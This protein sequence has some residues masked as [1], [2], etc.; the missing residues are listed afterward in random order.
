[1]RRKGD[2]SHGQSQA[3]RGNVPLIEVKSQESPRTALVTSRVT[4]IRAQEQ[5]FQSGPGP[6][7]NSG[8]G[9]S[10]PGFKPQHFFVVVW[11]QRLTM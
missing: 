1:M 11:R 4:G 9:G 7:A 2:C 5:V 10:L 8:E 3:D 6:L